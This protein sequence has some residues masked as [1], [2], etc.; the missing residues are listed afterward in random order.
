MVGPNPTRES[1]GDG[2]FPQSSEWSQ[3]AETLIERPTPF[4]SISSTLCR[5]SHDVLRWRAQDQTAPRFFHCKFW[6]ART[7]PRNVQLTKE[8]GLVTSRV[9]RSDSV[10]FIGT[11]SNC[12][13][14]ASRRSPSGRF[15]DTSISNNRL[16]ELVH[17]KLIPWAGRLSNGAEIASRL[18]KMQAKTPEMHRGKTKLQTL[19]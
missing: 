1:R 12:P 19:P 17:A 16:Y 4:T 9:G 15:L 5:F 2:G 6:K 7:F 3:P 8:V 18:C 14:C 11:A 13:H 10:A